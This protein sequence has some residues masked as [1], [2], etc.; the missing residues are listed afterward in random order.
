MTYEVSMLPSDNN[1]NLT[2]EQLKLVN[3]GITGTRLSYL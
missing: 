1:N 3:L 2:Y